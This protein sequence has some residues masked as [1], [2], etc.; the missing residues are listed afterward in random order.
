MTISQSIIEWL[1]GYDAVIEDVDTDLLAALQEPA[2]A[3]GFF[4][5]PDRIIV[6]FL[7]GTREITEY[8]QFLTRQNSQLDSERIDNQEFLADM[9]EWVYQKNLAREYPDIIG[10]RV[11]NIEVSNSFYVQ[12]SE[13]TEAVYQLSIGITYIR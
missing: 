1:N 10:V 9:E 13:E 3:Y 6:P 5:T 11:T 7:D 8:Y 4:K 2:E 12:Q